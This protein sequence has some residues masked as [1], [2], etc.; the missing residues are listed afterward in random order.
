MKDKSLKGLS[1]SKSTFKSKF[2]G[3]MGESYDGWHPSPML[4]H[5]KFKAQGVCA[6][7]VTDTNEIIDLAGVDHAIFSP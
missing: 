1:K 2:R 4:P 3:K 5:H 7:S 6:I